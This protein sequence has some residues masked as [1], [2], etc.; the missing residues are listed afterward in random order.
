MGLI[1]AQS[2]DYNLY[3]LSHQYLLVRVFL[4]SQIPSRTDYRLGCPFPHS[5]IP[6]APSPRP[7]AAVNRQ[8]NEAPGRGVMQPLTG[9]T[10]IHIQNSKFVIFQSD[11]NL[12]APRRKVLSA[13]LFPLCHRAECLSCCSKRHQPSSREVSELLGVSLESASSYYCGIGC[14][15]AHN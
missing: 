3:P 14:G 11:V 9:Q 6:W 7:K 4:K 15:S 8:S 12:E 13:C 10:Q 1:L 5:S 2:D